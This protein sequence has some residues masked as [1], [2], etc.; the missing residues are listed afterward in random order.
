[1]DLGI[2]GKRA[3][4][5]G[6]SAGMGRAIAMGLAREGA[7]VFLCSRSMDSLK[8]T[9]DEVS[10]V[11]KHGVEIATCDLSQET[12]RAALIDAVISRFG[13]VDILVH[14]TAGPTPTMAEDT[15]RDQWAQGFESLFQSVVHLNH[16]FVPAMK[17]Q[18]WGRII[19]I[20]SLSVLEP[21][22]NLAV[23]NAIRSAGTAMLKTLSDELASFD[24]TVNCVAPGSISTGRVEE[25]I[26]A[27]AKKSNVSQ[28]AYLADYIKAIP[29]GRMGSPEEFAS[30]VC[31]L[32]SAQASY[33][34]GSTIC[35]DGGRRRSTY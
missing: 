20:T 30:V 26:E 21:I 9:A 34:T 7:K 32:S 8:K 29:M 22:Q 3:L 1:M 4:V 25:L 14:N 13:G 5:C 27:R 12:S 16:A 11:A 33:V 15:T 19:N 2:D 10:K 18:K 35:V 23:S 6:A 28:D 31:F 17:E 24:I